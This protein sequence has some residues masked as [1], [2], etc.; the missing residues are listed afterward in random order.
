[1]NLGMVKSLL[2]YVQ[3]RYMFADWSNVEVVNGNTCAH[4]RQN[5]N[6]EF[7]L[8]GDVINITEEWLMN[9]PVTGLSV[10]N[11]HLI[12]IVDG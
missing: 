7:T 5:E 2:G 8:G 10:E 4:Y 6:G 11:N 12:I 9:L 1:M 3:G